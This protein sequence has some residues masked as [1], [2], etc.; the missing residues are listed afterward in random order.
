MG[1]LAADIQVSIISLRDLKSICGEMWKKLRMSLITEGI[2]V[3]KTTSSGR[4]IYLNPKRKADID[5]ILKE[6]LKGDED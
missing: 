4:H 6:G 2:L 5:R 3:E 1:I